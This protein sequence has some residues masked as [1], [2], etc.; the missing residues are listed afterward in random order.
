MDLAIFSI[1]L[2]GA[3]S[4]MGSINFIVTIVNMRAPGLKLTSMPL[5][6]WGILIASILLVITL[7]VLAS[8]LTMLLTD[9]NFNT[10]FFDPAGGGDVR[11]DRL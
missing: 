2:A 4:I 7:P 10:C 5:F 3:A 11:E 9:R 1:H 6:V 8:G